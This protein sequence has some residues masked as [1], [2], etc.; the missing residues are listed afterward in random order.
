MVV[1]VST[2]EGENK[3]MKLTDIINGNQ[4]VS[5]IHESDICISLALLDPATGES[6]RLDIKADMV[7]R[8]DEA[9]LF[10]EVQGLGVS[11]RPVVD[12]VDLGEWWARGDVLADDEVS[13]LFTCAEPNPTWTVTPDG[14][15]FDLRARRGGLF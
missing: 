10:V 12:Q 13:R 7:T 14:R 5:L 1:G 2:N 4:I 3:R 8:P 9:L 6:L 15:E 11:A